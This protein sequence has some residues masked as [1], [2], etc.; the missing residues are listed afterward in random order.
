MSSES[1][2]MEDILKKLNEAHNNADYVKEERAKGNVIVNENAKEMFNILSK[3]EE[4]TAN[5]SKTVVEES[6][7]D[8]GVAVGNKIGNTVSMGNY[9]VILEKKEVIKGVTKTFYH[10]EN[11]GKRVY[12]DIGLFESAMG[13][14]KGLLFDSK[15]SVINKIVELDERYCISL[16]EAA[17][18]KVKAKTLTES[19]KQDIAIAK[20]GNAVHRMSEL[21]KQIKSL[22]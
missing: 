11:D 16:Q 10:I 18:H 1:K 7:K 8:I 14:V 4:A 19:V 3:L 9:S 13:I 21:K 5:A 17:M 12:E 15:S 22:L 20:Q 6:K 2:S